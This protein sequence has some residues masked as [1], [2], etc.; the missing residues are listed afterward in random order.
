MSLFDFEPDVT[1][2]KQDG[3]R[4][5]DISNQWRRDAH[6]LCEVEFL[7]DLPI[8]EQHATLW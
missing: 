2:S 4:S 5:L 3:H 7:A 1:P 6:L 8:L